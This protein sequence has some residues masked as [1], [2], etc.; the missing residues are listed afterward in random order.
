MNAMSHRVPAGALL[1]SMLLVT[2]S[3]SATVYQVNRS[4]GAS[5][6]VTGFIETDGAL[7]TLLSDNLVNWEL[8]LTINDVSVVLA[9][10]NGVASTVSIFVD[11]T[12][13]E[14]IWR[15]DGNS[16]GAFVI[17]L[18][19]C[20]GT[21]RWR[22]T[23]GGFELIENLPD[24]PNQSSQY[25]LG[26]PDQVIGVFDPGPDMDGD[27]VADSLDNC[28][29]VFNVDQI[30]SNGDG[31]GN[32]CDGDFNGDCNVNPIDLGL[33]RQAFFGA[34]PDE[35][36]NGDGT[37]NAIDLGIFKTLFFQPPGPSALATC[38]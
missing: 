17:C 21:S 22:L 23:G 7:G 28:T 9:D 25:P 31:F 35:D 24:V 5:G 12:P 1:I 10:E 27:G 29:T 33:F 4:V 37:V 13:T 15:R 3:A 6:T 19:D 14:L 8:T 34:G 32:A 38:P 30:D 20:M 26:S 11:A 16:S 36:L 2:T 18:E